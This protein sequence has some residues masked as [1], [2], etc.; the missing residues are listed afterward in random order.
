MSY[1][2]HKKKIMFAIT[3]SHWGGAQRYLY[4][5]ATHLPQ[6]EFEIQAIM[7]KGGALADKLAE[8]KIPVHFFDTK[9]GIGIVQEIKTFITL[10]S[11]FRKEKPDIVHLNSSKM[12][13]LGAL[14]AR[15]SGVPHIVFT[16]HGWA[17]HE[18]RSFLERN[19]ILLSSWISSLMHHTIICVSDYDKRA[20]QKLPFIY[21]KC[22]TIKNAIRTPELLDK[23]KARTLLKKESGIESGPQYTWIGTIAELTKNKGLTHLIRSLGTMPHRAWT[24]VIIGEGE[25]R[26]KLKRKIVRLG[27]EKNIFLAGHIQNAQSFLNAFDIFVL[28]SVKEGFPYA[29]LEAGSAGLPVVASDVGGVPEIIHGGKTGLL[30]EPK[31]EAML[32]SHIQTL[33]ENPKLRNHFGTALNEKIGKEFRFENTLAQTIEAYKK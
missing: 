26:Q 1:T 17:F 22:V 19:L 13:G 9:R 7:G 28:P 8:A 27:L 23:I 2:P 5:L 33:M 20:A 4:D 12:G 15:L 6:N 16:V 29:L 10:L 14:A 30:A 3:R 21:K 24:C 18:D 11:I 32:A 31:N 25:E